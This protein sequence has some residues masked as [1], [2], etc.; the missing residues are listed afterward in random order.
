M[1]S[2][3]SYGVRSRRSAANAGV[4]LTAR[5]YGKAR[6]GTYAEKADGHITV[7]SDAERLIAHVL[8]VDPRVRSFKQQPFTVDLVGERLLF[9]RED[10]SEAR[11]MRGNRAGD[12]EYTPDFATV[13]VDGLQRAYEVKLQGFEGDDRYWAKV[14]RA[15]EIMA[16]YCY[17]LSTLVVPADERHPVI[18]NAQLLKPAIARAR[19]YLTPDIIDL[20]ESYCESGPVLQRAL[21][22]DLQIPTGL[23]PQLLAKGVLKADLAHHHICATLK[24]SAAYGDLG[25]L[26]LIEELRP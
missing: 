24:L 2:A 21:C 10:V 14:E 4:R 18:V 5:T 23:I 6:I 12:V 19:E 11:K 3:P 9:T 13:Q 20:V 7:E 22:A 15:G 8:S 16:A 26:C 1:R 25:H 17:P